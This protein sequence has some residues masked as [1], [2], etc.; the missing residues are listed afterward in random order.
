MGYE[1]I[2]PGKGFAVVTHVDRDSI[3]HAAN[4]L[5][6]QGHFSSVIAVCTDALVGYSDDLEIR[7]LL[8]RALLALRKDKAAERQIS[9][10]LRLDSTSSI[11]YQMF[12][13]IAFRHD[14]L[15]T[16]EIYFREACRLDRAN[17]SARIWLDV[18]LVSSGFSPLEDSLSASGATDRTMATPVTLRPASCR[19]FADGTAPQLQVDDPQAANPHEVTRIAN[20]TTSDTRASLGATLKVPQLK[21]SLDTRET[22]SATPSP[23]PQVALRETLQATALE[24]ARA[25][26]QA[27]VSKPSAETVVGRV[28]RAP[29]RPGAPRRRRRR[30]PAS[31]TP[32]KN[33]IGGYLVD[34]GMLSIAQLSDALSYHRQ[35]HVRVGDAAVALGFISEQKLGWAAIGFHSR[36]R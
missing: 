19:R 15:S 25:T 9:E 32:H 5:F 23:T 10:I 24:T 22:P 30:T 26:A 3:T 21:T 6:Q 35:N 2:D 16:A 34:N 29:S 11:A 13:E 8:A 20:M 18:T 1:Q 7:T 12:G 31:A 36:R 4:E 17:A 27:T 33:R 14:D 28:K